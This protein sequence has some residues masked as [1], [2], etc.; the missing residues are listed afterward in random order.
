M[1][2][3]DYSCADDL[4]GVGDRRTDRAGLRAGLRCVHACFDVSACE[5]DYGT[6][7]KELCKNVHVV[8][9][10]MARLMVCE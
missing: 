7:W 4:V 2:S 1:V 10:N 5:Q 3:T 9:N 8:N 6:G